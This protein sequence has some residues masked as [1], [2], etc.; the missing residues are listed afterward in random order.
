MSL[1]LTISFNLFLQVVLKDTPIASHLATSDLL[2]FAVSC[3]I[4]FNAAKGHI[5]ETVQFR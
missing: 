5:N 4:L 2:N 3:R 1:I